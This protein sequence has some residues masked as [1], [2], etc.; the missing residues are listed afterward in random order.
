[1]EGVP[2]GTV[3]RAPLDRRGLAFGAVYGLAAILIAA[4]V[5]DLG[6]TRWWLAAVCA[7]VAVASAHWALRRAARTEVRADGLRVSY[8]PRRPARHA[9]T[10]IAGFEAVD[11]GDDPD[12]AARV[13]RRVRMRL[14][15]GDAVELPGIGGA[16]A[17]AAARALQARLD[18]R[19]G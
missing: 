19:Q 15:D 17:D 14:R 3:F 4:G 11:P 7:L 8:P 12:A 6:S 10:D 9:W 1:M 5:L 2:D 13:G 16:G 18:R